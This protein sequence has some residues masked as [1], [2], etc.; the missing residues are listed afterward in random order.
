MCRHLW[1]IISHSLKENIN[2]F[3]MSI[4]T[5]GSKTQANPSFSYIQGQLDYFMS[6]LQLSMETENPS[7]NIFASIFVTLL[8]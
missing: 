4:Q 6:Q 5:K 1:Y 7:R 2:F 8:L 3:L